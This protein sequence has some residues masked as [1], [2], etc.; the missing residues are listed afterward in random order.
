MEGFGVKRTKFLAV[1]LALAAS[2]LAAQEAP[3]SHAARQQYA[4]WQAE[5]SDLWINDA[6]A[7]ESAPYDGSHDPWCGDGCYE[8]CC[9]MSCCGAG[10][11]GGC[12]CCCP[13]WVAYGD[14]L[15]WRTSRSGLDYV[16]V[17]M[18]GQMTDGIEAS[19]RYVDPSFDSGGFRVGMYRVGPGCWDVGGRFTRFAT[20]DSAATFA[21]NNTLIPT[22]IP[23]PFLSFEDGVEFAESTYAVDLDVV[24]IEVGYHLVRNCRTNVRAFGGARLAFIDQRMDSFYRSVWEDDLIS[25]LF[26]SLDTTVQERL[27]M[28]A[29]GAMV[30]IEGRT[31]LHNRITAFGRASAG[32]LLANFSG[33]L[34][35]SRDSDDQVVAAENGGTVTIKYGEQRMISTLDIAGGFGYILVENCRQTLELQAG[36]ELQGWFNMADFL[37]LTERQAANSARND[38]TLGFDG[39]FIR[40]V[41]TW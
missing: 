22:R 14:W 38:A 29:Y 21:P 4:A 41:G 11:G 26:F 36:Y 24:D 35:L 12:G 23:A 1:W 19:L 40:L 7:V 2:P 8:P 28:D 20:R 34:S 39:V 15:H 10:C 9:Q 3:R 18:E 25:S 32:L 37:N 27:N 30:G 17:G 31:R 33:R 5:A 13:A 16:A 6:E